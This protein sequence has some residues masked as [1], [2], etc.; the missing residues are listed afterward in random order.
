[1]GS[2]SSKKK[3]A[4][5]SQAL[6]TSAVASSSDKDYLFK[7]MLLGDSSAFIFARES[8]WHLH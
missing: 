8:L 6:K 7:V 2:K 1:M 3:S 4:A 5:P